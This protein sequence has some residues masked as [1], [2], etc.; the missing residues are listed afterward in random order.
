MLSSGSLKYFRGKKKRR[1]QPK[2]RRVPLYKSQG[3]PLKRG[4]RR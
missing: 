4:V 1:L 3:R 2:K